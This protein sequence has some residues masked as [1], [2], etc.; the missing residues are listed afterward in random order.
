M[1][2][3]LVILPFHSGDFQIALNLLEWIRDLGRHSGTHELL[4]LGS[5]RSLNVEMLR[6]KEAAL[7]T[8]IS[9][10]TDRAPGLPDE[11]WPKG[12]NIMF[13]RAC[14]LVQKR[15]R[16]PFLWME[17]DCVPMKPGWLDA[18][19]AEYESC[20]KPFM[21][22]IRRQTSNPTL[23]ETYLPGCSIYPA[24]AF[25]RLSE[26]WEPITS[27][28]D[29]S[30]AHVT[31]PNA[32][33]SFL[34]YEWWG[35]NGKPPTFKLGRRTTDPIEVMVP[36][37]IPKEAVF[38]HRS[39]DGSL[40]KCLR[41]LMSIPAIPSH[42]PPSIITSS[43]PCLIMLGGV[44]DVLIAMPIAW[45]Y[46]KVHGAPVPFVTSAQCVGLFD[47]ASYIRPVSRQ[48]VDWTSY[49]EAI[50]WAQKHFKKVLPL[51]AGEPEILRNLR[52]SH[53][54]HEQ[55]RLAEVTGEYGNFP[56]VFDRRNPA[57]EADLIAK[58]SNDKPLFL[59][60]F[61]GKT[62]PMA[63]SPHVLASIRNNWGNRLNLV[64]TGDLALAHYHD[65]LGLLEKSIGMIAIDTSNLHLMAASQTPYIALLNDTRI[66]W[67]ATVPRGNCVFRIGYTRV[68]DS[69]GRINE[70]IENM[71]RSFPKQREKTK[72]LIVTL[73]CNGM[74]QVWDVARQTWEP[75][76]E[77][78]GYDLECVKI[79]PNQS[80]HPSWNKLHVV[81]DSLERA[82][83]VWWVDSD[84]TVARTE[85]P[86][87]IPSHELAFAQDWNGLCGCMF[88]ARD[89]SWT[90]AF[91]SAAIT[92]GDVGNEDQ[93][94]RGLGPK[95][96][97]NAIKLLAR[98][99]PGVANKI[100]YLKS[101]IVNDH[102]HEDRG[103]VFCHFGA[104]SNAQRI[105]AMKAR[106]HL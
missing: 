62:S 21:G 24:D 49:N 8:F 63:S 60:N 102:P 103:E 12:A 36:D 72:P 44:G 37:Q 3:L 106:H 32:I 82:Q 64:N 66:P 67:S 105:A 68:M 9:V 94:G 58:V 75:Y 16:M 7:S 53:F 104:R 93:F 83:N 74:E 101:G 45:H 90:R 19:A 65:M 4:I 61:T 27:A 17:P 15:H 48:G 69:L 71:L 99:F 97:Q 25:T 55:Y 35:M 6:L 20:G 85:E 46:S 79:A 77:R 87:A 42:T 41:E 57:R 88:F 50:T 81:L 22:G 91:L 38:F 23:P 86:L 78:H 28:W 100:G 76:C 31:V 10:V 52:T 92:V 5:H 43:P 70:T 98:E 59:Y 47:G 29:V 26:S 13:R 30:T 95:W 84:M 39:K 40:I 11:S 2:P 14:E 33:K 51:H 80:L 96:E 89:T 56:L 54:C 73:A 34:F 1:K 18:I